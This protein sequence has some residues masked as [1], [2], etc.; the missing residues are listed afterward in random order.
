[1]DIKTNYFWRIF[2]AFWGCVSKAENRVGIDGVLIERAD[3]NTFNLVATD[4]HIML[5]GEFPFEKYYLLRVLLPV[6][7]MP[8]KFK[9]GVLFKKGLCYVFEPV[10]ALYPDYKKLFKREFKNP[11]DRYPVFSFE[12][13]DKVRKVYKR[14]GYKGIDQ[15]YVPDQWQNQISVTVKTIKNYTL[16]VMPIRTTDSGRIWGI[17]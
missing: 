11:R 14:I 4:G 17:K 6:L 13:L 10:R 9:D 7:P 2:K 15:G 5:K 1:M 8:N 3:K 16:V 12:V